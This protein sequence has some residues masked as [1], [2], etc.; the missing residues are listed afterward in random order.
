MPEQRRNALKIIGAVGTT[1]A[2]PFAADELYG[3]QDH[4]AHAVPGKQA[5]A[6][7]PK[8]FKP[9]EMKLLA[10]CRSDYSGHR[11]ALGFG[12]WSAFVH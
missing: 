12:C 10:D 5:P 8:Y 1:C 11:Y 4:S 7:P 9:A 3:Q 2:F 6:A